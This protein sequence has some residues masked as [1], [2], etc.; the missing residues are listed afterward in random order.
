MKKI[1]ITVFALW[2]CTLSYA[3]LDKDQ[4]ALE[5]SKAEAAN[6]EKLKAFIWK[7]H[8]TATVQGEVKATIIN[9]ISFNEEGEVQVTTVGGES[10][11][12]QKRGLRGRAQKSAMED[13]QEYIEKA[14]Q[15]SM[16]YTHMSK[17]Q[18]IDFFEKAMVTENDEIIE[19]SAENVYVDGDRLTVQIEA[20]TKLFIHKRFS[21]KMGEDPIEG[22][23]KYDKFSSGISHV[24]E[25]IM[26]L[27]GKGAVI[28]AKNQ[29]YSQRIE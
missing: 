12:K 26:N 11:I 24:T 13:N 22:E 10:N 29:D 21:S 6:L 19:L 8:S 9:E 4:L 18:L 2:S 14:L 7:R 23:I 5:V 15:L 17:G 25:T 27:A 28:N 16:A 3:Q 20:A 1:L